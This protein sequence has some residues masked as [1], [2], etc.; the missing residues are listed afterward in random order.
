MKNIKDFIIKT[1]KMMV[2]VLSGPLCKDMKEWIEA[3]EERKRFEKEFQEPVK[4][5]IKEFSE[6]VDS[7]LES[8]GLTYYKKNEFHCDSACEAPIYDVQFNE[9]YNVCISLNP[10]NTY[11]QET[12]DRKTTSY[13]YNKLKDK[14]EEFK[15]TIEYCINKYG[16]Y[17]GEY[18]NE[19]TN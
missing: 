7:Y 3:E 18:E 6:K 8:K 16:I 5:C 9:G 17:K 19:T 2:I 13:I 10:G 11:I 15:Q 14:Y 4:S 12:K 1:L